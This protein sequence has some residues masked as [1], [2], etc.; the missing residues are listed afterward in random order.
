MSWLRGSTWT[1]SI[2][3]IGS[4]T[5]S[6]GAAVP[7]QLLVNS[8]SVGG[9]WSCSL[10]RTG[11]R[12]VS[13]CLDPC[14]A[15]GPFW[16][17]FFKQPAPAAVCSCQ[18]MYLNVCLCFY[19][20]VNVGLPMCI[21]WGGGISGWWTSYMYVCVVLCFLDSSKGA[22]P[23][24]KC[25]YIFLVDKIILLEMTNIS[26]GQKGKTNVKKSGG[27]T[28]NNRKNNYLA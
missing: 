13:F 20:H 14:D 5:S 18:C 24:N 15:P 28:F 10:A 19:V 16:K 26:A 3:H 21:I 25:S 8:W 4:L 17:V 27:F 2:S 12:W 11:S 22:Y 6:D 7:V 9:C 1:E 23:S